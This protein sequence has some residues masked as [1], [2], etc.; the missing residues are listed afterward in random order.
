MGVK[1]YAIASSVSLI[2]AQRLARR[3]CENC[4]EPIDVPP[5]ALLKGRLSGKKI[6]MQALPFITARAAIFATEAIAAASA[7]IR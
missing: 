4:K 7:S 3:L 5:E 2:I 6:L 1:P